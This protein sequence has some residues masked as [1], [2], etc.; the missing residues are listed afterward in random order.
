MLYHIYQMQ[1]IILW[2][3][4]IYMPL[5]FQ[6]F[7]LVKQELSSLDVTSSHLIGIFIK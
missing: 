1:K 4:C 6:G 5:I 7:A 2:Y 3:D